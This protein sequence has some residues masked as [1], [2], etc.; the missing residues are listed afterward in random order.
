MAAC[1]G[2]IAKTAG[3]HY[4]GATAR[5]G[6]IPSPEHAAPPKCHA[7]RQNLRRHCAARAERVTFGAINETQRTAMG[8]HRNRTRDL[9]PRLRTPP[10]VARQVSAW[11]V[12]GV[13]YVQLLLAAVLA[14]SMPVASADAGVEAIPLCHLQSLDDDQGRGPGNGPVDQACCPLCAFHARAAVLAPPLPAL[15]EWRVA[16]L[17][18][19]APEPFA[20]KPFRRL[21]GSASSRGPPARG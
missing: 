17:A 2:A 21:P 7:S 20:L 3:S 11:L 14:G 8:P 9:P 1:L 10:S 18:P 19:A 6:T 4:S 5:P 16:A 12:A 15:L 13:F